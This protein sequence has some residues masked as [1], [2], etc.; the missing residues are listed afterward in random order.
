MLIVCPSCDAQYQVPESAIPPEGR[1]VQCSSC[2][3]KWHQEPASKSAPEP[4][5]ARRDLPEQSRTVQ[6][7]A[8]DEDRAESDQDDAPT[9]APADQRRGGLFRRTRDEFRVPPPPPESAGPDDDDMPAPEPDAEIAAPA[10]QR[11]DDAAVAALAPDEF[12]DLPDEG[13]SEDDLADLAAL[14]APQ[15]DLAQPKDDLSDIDPDDEMLGDDEPPASFAPI[16]EQAARFTHSPHPRL[17]DDA[18]PPRAWDLPDDDA[19]TDP[20]DEF[21]ATPPEPAQSTAPDAADGGFLWETPDDDQVDLSDDWTPPAPIQPP[22]QPPV[23]DHASAPEITAAARPGRKL[24]DALAELSALQRNVAEAREA[25]VPLDEVRRARN[26]SAAAE[27]PTP[28]G[29]TPPPANDESEILATIRSELLR[30]EKDSRNRV[31]D[32]DQLR[33]SLREGVGAK[34]RKSRADTRTPKTKRAKST[35]PRP[36]RARR[37]G[38]RLA[39]AL[40]VLGLIAYLFS[41]QIANIYPPAGPYLQSFS[42]IVDTLRELAQGLV[43]RLIAMVRSE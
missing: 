35:G 39:L 41:A 40:F 32:A 29:E 13:P 16:Q 9:V 37:F 6:P 14:D 23:Q 42:G 30:S 11:D 7:D 38:T 33:A 22:V 21:I 8:A 24:T 4:L 17:D 27:R 31:T 3:T 1:E 5:V 28:E 18:E 15:D 34:P 36:G 20:D 10:A 2:D 26:E 43:Q 19:A 12:D 25:P